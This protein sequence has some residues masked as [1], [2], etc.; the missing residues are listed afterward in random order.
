MPLIQKPTK[1]Y[2]DQNGEFVYHGFKI[3]Y[4]RFKVLAL[5]LNVGEAE[6]CFLKIFL[7]KHRAKWPTNQVN[8][9]VQLDK[10][11]RPTIS[12]VFKYTF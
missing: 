8:F 6:M 3:I 10:S 5:K 4:K 1:I 11:K 9:F 7:S 12:V 2:A